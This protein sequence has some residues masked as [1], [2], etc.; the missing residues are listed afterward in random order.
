[1]EGLLSL[2]QRKSIPK[3]LF[4]S[5]QIIKIGNNTK[6]VIVTSSTGIS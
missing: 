1:L 3:E 6:Y 4:F 5:S 2:S